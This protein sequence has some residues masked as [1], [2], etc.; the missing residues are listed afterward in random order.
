[1]NR[2]GSENAAGASFDSNQQSKNEASEQCSPLRLNLE[3]IGHHDV[4]P[5]A[6]N[7]AS[8]I[9]PMNRFDAAEMEKVERKR[10]QGKIPDLD[11]DSN[12]KGSI[13]MSK[14]I[15]LFSNKMAPN[16]S[17]SL[18]SFKKIF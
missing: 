13:I 1:M 3:D 7:A 14:V 15:K 11:L 5:T 18:E 9:I 4:L 6:S 2:D 12:I 17:S 16:F 10:R 8:S